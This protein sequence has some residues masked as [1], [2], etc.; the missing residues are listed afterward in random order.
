MKR[1]L[2][3]IVAVIATMVAAMVASS[4]CMFFTYQPKEPECLRE[5]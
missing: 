4:A 1:K 3:S 5:E 2:F